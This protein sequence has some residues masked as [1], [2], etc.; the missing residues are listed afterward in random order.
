MGL[1]MSHFRNDNGL[2]HQFRTN[3]LIGALAGLILLRL[4]SIGSFGYHLALWYFGLYGTIEISL[5][6][7]IRGWNGLN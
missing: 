4:V 6:L 5:S 2:F 1:K 3:R 7:R